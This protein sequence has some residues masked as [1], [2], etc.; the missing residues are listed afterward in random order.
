M[1]VSTTKRSDVPPLPAPVHSQAVISPSSSHRTESEPPLGSTLIPLLALA[2]KVPSCGMRNTWNGPTLTKRIPT[3]AA[4]CLRTG[5]WTGA[6]LMTGRCT[7]GRVGTPNLVVRRSRTEWT[8][9]RQAR[10]GSGS[11]R[12]RRPRPRRPRSRGTRSGAGRCP[13]T[14]RTP[15]FRHAGTSGARGAGRCWCRARP[16]ATRCRPGPAARRR[17]S[18]LD[19]EA[20]DLVAA[21]R[22]V[23][24]EHERD[25]GP[26][27]RDEGGRPVRPDG[28]LVAEDD[29]GRAVREPDQ[30][31]LDLDGGGVGVDL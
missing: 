11:G 28:E 19:P 30:P 31:P 18:S 23:L 16:A 12:G 29:R 5:D 21:A 2:G 26:R 24:G 25:Q 9:M 4:S 10:G 6:G 7:R 15:P 17:G 13:R 3:R 1:I 20:D 22:E 8:I 27:L 14:P